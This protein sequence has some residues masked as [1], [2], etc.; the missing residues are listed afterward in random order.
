MCKRQHMFQLFFLLHMFNF[1]IKSSAASVEF[2]FCRQRN[3]MTQDIK[4]SEKFDSKLFETMSEDKIIF[5]KFDSK[6][7]LCSLLRWIQCSIFVLI[8]LLL[9]ACLSDFWVKIGDSDDSTN[10]FFTVKTQTVLTLENYAESLRSEL[11]T[12]QICSNLQRKSTSNF[13]TSHSLLSQDGK[14]FNS[15]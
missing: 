5:E 9:L 3:N 4:R 14:P 1:D 6:L 12:F 11:R 13:N 2:K 8:H 7:F 15:V 10:N